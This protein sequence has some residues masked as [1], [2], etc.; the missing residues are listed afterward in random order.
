MAQTAS[1]CKLLLQPSKVCLEAQSGQW[2]Y[3]HGKSSGQ[4]ALRL[5][6]TRSMVDKLDR[7]GFSRDFCPVQQPL[8]RFPVSILFTAKKLHTLDTPNFTEKNCI[9]LIT[10][11]LNKNQKVHYLSSIYLP[12]L[13]SDLKFNRPFYFP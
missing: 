2:G 3:L 7:N 9:L 11:F 4:Q 1:G 12:K 13:N 5:I 6:K 8:T 10:K